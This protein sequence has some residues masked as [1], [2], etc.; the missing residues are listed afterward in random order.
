[1]TITDKLASIA[2]LPVNKWNFRS[3]KKAQKKR[4]KCYGQYG[5]EKSFKLVLTNLF[6]YQKT[7]HRND[8]A[9]FEEKTAKNHYFDARGVWCP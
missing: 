3:G 7:H 8:I 1:M 5:Q 6:A 4:F 9:N 2:S